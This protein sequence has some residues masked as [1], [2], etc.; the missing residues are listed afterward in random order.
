ML[1]VMTVVVTLVI[2]GLGFVCGSKWSRRTVAKT[3][4]EFMAGDLT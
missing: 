1:E 4:R 3:W 2:F